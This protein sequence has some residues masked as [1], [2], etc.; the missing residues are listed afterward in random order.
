MPNPDVRPEDGITDYYRDHTQRCQ[1]PKAK[2][3]I[4]DQT[5]PCAVTSYIMNLYLGESTLGHSRGA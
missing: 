5:P 2:E 3:P 1:S 4:M